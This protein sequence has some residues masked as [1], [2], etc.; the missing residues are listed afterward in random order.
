SL[1]T[2]FIELTGSATHASSGAYTFDA[3]KFTGP[4]YSGRTDGNAKTLTL[5]N[6]SVLVNLQPGMLVTGTTITGT[7][8]IASILAG[9]IQLK[10]EGNATVT[11]GQDNYVFTGGL[12]DYAAQALL[13]LWY[14]WSDYY[15]SYV[16]SQNPFTNSMTGTI[17]AANLAQITF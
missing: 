12:S 8:R 10:L 3:S 7:V 9:V 4:D 5:K 15:V 11:S 2:N 16:Q 17:N 14:A 13:N 6:L 1:G